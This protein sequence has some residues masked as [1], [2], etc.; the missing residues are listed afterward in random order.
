MSKGCFMWQVHHFHMEAI[1]ADSE[2]FW[3]PAK[4]SWIP[5]DWRIRS[6]DKP[7]KNQ[8]SI[9]VFIWCWVS[10][11]FTEVCKYDIFR[12]TKRFSD[13]W[14]YKASQHLR[15]LKRKARG[16]WW[17]VSVESFSSLAVSPAESW[18]HQIYPNNTRGKSYLSLRCNVDSWERCQAYINLCERIRCVTF[19]TKPAGHLQK[20][21][22]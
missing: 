2:D 21:Q 1:Q 9:T 17:A 14:N 15:L 22:F 4:L 16:K 20:E 10:W 5:Q 3:K 8:E 13:P 7:I 11:L 12:E 19:H 6:G 18:H